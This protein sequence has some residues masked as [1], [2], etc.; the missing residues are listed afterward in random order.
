MS[1]FISLTYVCCNIYQVG[2]SYYAVCDNSW[3]ISKF[4]AS[5]TPF[6]ESNVQIGDPNREE[7]DSGYEAIIHHNN[8][9]YVI[10]ESVQF[11]HILESEGTNITK[12]HAVIEE[13]ILNEDDYEIRDQCKCE[14]EFEGDS[15]GFEG[16]FGMPGIDGEFYIVGLCEGNH[17]SES[18]KFHKGHGQMIMMKKNASHPEGCI[19]ETVKNISIPKT[20][21]FRDYSDI[22]VTNDGKIAITSQEDS[23]LWI[24]Q[25]FGV[26]DGFIDPENIVF[27]ESA[28][29]VYDFPKSNEC[30]TVYCNIEGIT[31]INDEMVMAVSDKMKG[32]GKQSFW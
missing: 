6:S 28:Y 19:W 16:G 5:L 10:R 21:H 14:F 31:F 4:D 27:N 9:F 13:I 7:E 2:D 32:K 30:L 1:I 22:D 17:C 15:K 3:A 24:G 11:V 25:L 23:A 12:Y 8:T 26:E 29:L 18:R 20:A